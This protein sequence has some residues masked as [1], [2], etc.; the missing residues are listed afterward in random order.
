MSVNL[1]DNNRHIILYT[2]H[3]VR[4]NYAPAKMNLFLG[5]KKK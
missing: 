3:M 4:L 2:F 5:L 1:K